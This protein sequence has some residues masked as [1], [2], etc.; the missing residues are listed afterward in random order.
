MLPMRPHSIPSGIPSANQNARPCTPPPVST[1]SLPALPGQ[2]RKDHLSRTCLNSHPFPEPSPR[3]PRAGEAVTAGQRAANV[4]ER[5]VPDWGC[6]PR[7]GVMVFPRGL[8]PGAAVWSE[9]L[10]VGNS[11]IPIPFPSL[12]YRSCLLGKYIKALTTYALHWIYGEQISSLTK[13]QQPTAFTLTT[14]TLP[15]TLEDAS[16]MSSIAAFSS[17]RL[18]SLQTANPEPNTGKVG[19]GTRQPPSSSS[20]SPSDSVLFLRI[21][22]AADYFTLNATLMEN[23]PPVLVDVIL[24]PYLLNV[25]PRSLVP[26]AGWVVLVAGFAWVIAKGV[27]RMFTGIVE[28]AEAADREGKKKK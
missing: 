25:F 24:D 1:P 4:S 8:D 19:R 16:L 12:V 23:V 11:R 20:P 5:V 26:T 13:Q 21:H 15:S 14:H 28:E 6:A 9:G 3:W 17:A 22:A 2:R 7:N 10:L 27:V 18:A